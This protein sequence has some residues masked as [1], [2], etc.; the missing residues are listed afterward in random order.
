MDDQII[1]FTNKLGSNRQAPGNSRYLGVGEQHWNDGSQGDRLAPT[2]R[3]FGYGG[4]W[5]LWGDEE[6]G[7]LLQ[8]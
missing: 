1:K 6:E 5:N 8:P 4:T 3:V 2:G 7:G